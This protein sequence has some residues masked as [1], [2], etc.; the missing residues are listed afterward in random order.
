MQKLSKLALAMLAGA[1]LSA[2]SMA[3]DQ[4]FV[5]VNGASVSQASADM[6]IEQGKARGMPDTPEMRNQI[7]EELIGRELLFQEAMKS[8]YGKKPEIAAQAEAEKKKILAQAE[9]TRQAV[10]IRAYVQDF[11]RK[12][13][14]TDAQLK[15]EYDALRSKGG[16]T[17]YKVR[18]I[19][20]KNEEEAKALHFGV[21]WNCH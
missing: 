16:D 17:E 4:P 21:S 3:A 14:T 7:R 13:P 11:V 2:P 5:T 19:L 12:N 18:H 10:F 20:V 8:G 1:I 9:A 15:A 6:F